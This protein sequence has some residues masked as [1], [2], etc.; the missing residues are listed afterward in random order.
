MIR[1]KLL[2]L[3]QIEQVPASAWP[4]R[5]AL[6]AATGHHHTHQAHLED[7]ASSLLAAEDRHKY[8]SFERW[9]NSSQNALKM[10]PLLKDCIMLLFKKSCKCRHGSSLLS[11][12]SDKNGVKSNSDATAWKDA[13]EKMPWKVQT[14]KNS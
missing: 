3:F 6:F 7:V 14:L 10:V 2:S 9:K 1:I 4:S 11:I 8:V 12:G 13:N 5:L